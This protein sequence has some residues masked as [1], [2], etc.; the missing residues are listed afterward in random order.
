VIG[1][2]ALLV[3]VL[4]LGACSSKDD[5]SI[6]AYGSRCIDGD[7]KTMMFRV[8]DRGESYDIAIYGDLSMQRFDSGCVMTIDKKTQK[9]VKI[10]LSQ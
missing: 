1:R 6:R 7:P 4:L 10:M 8:N 3:P 5:L 2:S 9:V